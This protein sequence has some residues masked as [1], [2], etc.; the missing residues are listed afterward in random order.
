MSLLKLHQ[1]SSCGGEVQVLD[2]SR[3]FFKEW[4]MEH[5]NGLLRE[6]VESLFLKVFN[7]MWNSV[8]WSC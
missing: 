8:T 6:V 3:N 1:I 5:W 4:V 2:I 7:W